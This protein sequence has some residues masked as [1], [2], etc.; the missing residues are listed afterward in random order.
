MNGKRAIKFSLIAAGAIALLLVSISPSQAQCAMCRSAL[1][2]SPTGAKLSQS[3]NFAILVLLIP[4]VMIF[5]GIFLAAFKYRK[6]A[7]EAQPEGR[8]KR[9]L[10]GWFGRLKTGRRGHRKQESAPIP[11]PGVR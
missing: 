7:D 2:G 9:G 10:R 6:A 1:S 3:F 5:C 11:A 4:P 8:Q